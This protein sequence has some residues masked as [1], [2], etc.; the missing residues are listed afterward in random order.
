MTA[1]GEELLVVSL[2]PGEGRNTRAHPGIRAALCAA[3][4]LDGWVAGMAL[5][6]EKELRKH[7]RK[8]S[9]GTLEPALAPLVAAGRV[10]TTGRMTKYDWLA[11]PAWGAAVRERLT[12]SLSG[13]SA[14]AR[15]DAALTVLLYSGSLWDW[16]FDPP[17]GPGLHLVRPRPSP[18]RDRAAMLA[19][20]AVIPDGAAAADLSSV[21]R[22]LRREVR[23]AD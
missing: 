13:P 2:H 4:V 8:N 11:D 10:T 17:Q 12:A 5:P 23:N 20:G 19:S 18:L 14:P 16:A 3:P 15:H 21:A 22:V 6:P 9:F 7:V 1:L